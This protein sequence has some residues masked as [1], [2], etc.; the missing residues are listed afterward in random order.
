MIWESYPWKKRLLRLTERLSKRTNQKR[1]LESTSESVE[2]DIF[3]AAYI[4]R[5]LIEANKISTSNMSGKLNLIAYPALNKNVTKMNRLEINELYDFSRPKPI[6]KGVQFILN[7]IIHSYVFALCF[8]EAH[9]LDAIF[10]SSEYERHKYLYFIEIGDLITYFKR[11]GNDYPN[12]SAAIFNEKKRDYEFRQEMKF[13]IRP[14]DIVS[15]WQKISKQ[16]EDKAD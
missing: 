15:F 5:K 4:V 1:W 6:F 12:V 14:Q 11:V 8:D 2:A 16:E 10:V 13:N 7:Q 3:M 9:K